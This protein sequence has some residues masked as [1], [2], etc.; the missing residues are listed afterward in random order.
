M[1]T[2]FDAPTVAE[3]AREIDAL[4]RSGHSPLDV[5]LKRM[6]RLANELMALSFAPQRLWLLDQLEHELTAYNMP[7]AWR[8]R[9]PLDVEALRRAF[10]ATMKDP[11]Y[12]GRLRKANI[13]YNPMVGEE[14]TQEVLRTLNAPLSLIER[15]QAAIN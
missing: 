4:R 12:V 6:D 5:P 9:G 10:D 1:R 15:Y 7:Y 3:L 14:L 2:L 13:Q 8:L 11:S